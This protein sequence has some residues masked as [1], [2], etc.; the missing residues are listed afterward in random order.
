[1]RCHGVALRTFAVAASMFAAI[2][3]S[4]HPAQAQSRA[5]SAAVLLD[6]ARRFEQES[7]AEVAS[8][9][10]SLILQRYGDT[11]AAAAVR[12]RSREGRVILDRSGR[13]ELLVWGTTYGL[14]LGVA[15]PLILDA[16]GPEAYGI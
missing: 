2:A 5:D 3:V 7:R 11:P 13:T 6:S 1:M 12:A 16:D 10:Y 9:L 8:A 15:V 14:W 4:A